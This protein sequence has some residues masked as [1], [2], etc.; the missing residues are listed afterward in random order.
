LA[1]DPP[2][3]VAAIT[4]AFRSRGPIDPKPKIKK[5]STSEEKMTAFDKALDDYFSRV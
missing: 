5:G 3:G 2:S 4:K 1:Y